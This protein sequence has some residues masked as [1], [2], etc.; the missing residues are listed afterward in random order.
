M[1]QGLT[2]REYRYIHKEL[3]RNYGK[4]DHCVLCGSKNSNRYEWALIHGYSYDTN[5]NHYMQLCVKCHR[6][7]DFN[8]DSR[9]KNRN[10]NKGLV[11]SDEIRKR[12]SDGHKGIS[13]TED[14]KLNLSE[15]IK[16]SWIK[17]RKNGRRNRNS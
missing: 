8:E 17:R 16:R 7:Y 2:D 12:T 1:K 14:H 4:A 6:K 11:R 10:S 15:S 5:P 9:I 3:V 13:F